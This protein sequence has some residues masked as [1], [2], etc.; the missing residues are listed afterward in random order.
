[1]VHAAHLAI[2]EELWT[3][4]NQSNQPMQRLLERLGFLPSGVIEGLD[5][6]DPELVFRLL[7]ERFHPPF[8]A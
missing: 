1:M 5:E 4:T 2:G 3:S 8:V 6:G 7:P